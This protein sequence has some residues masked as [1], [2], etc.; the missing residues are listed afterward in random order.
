MSVRH[1]LHRLADAR[2][3]TGEPDEANPVGT[4]DSARELIGRRLAAL[5]ADV[6]SMLATAAPI[7][8]HVDPAV[9]ATVARTSAET[10]TATLDPLA[11]KGFLIRDDH[12]YRWTHDEVRQAALALTPA[13]ERDALRLRIGRALLSDGRPDAVTHL[14]ATMHL[15]DDR[16][17]TTPPGSPRCPTIRGGTGRTSRSRCTCAPRRPSTWPA[18]RPAPCNCW[19]GRWYG[20]TST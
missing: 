17:H 5:P 2:I 15:L 19:T 11:P 10:V 20:R 6:R 16:A 3:L 8:A 9:L 13:D 18:T 1:F 12:G 14:N 4:G 7:G